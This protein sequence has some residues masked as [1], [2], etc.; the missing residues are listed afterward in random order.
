[1]STLTTQEYLRSQYGDSSNL[2]ARAGL[3]VRFSTEEYPWFHRVFDHF[4]IPDDGRLLDLGC[5]T[6]PLWRDNLE[7]IPRGWSVT[8]SDAS[9]GMVRDRER[10][11]KSV[12][13]KHP[14]HCQSHE[15]EDR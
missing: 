10:T 12:P 6:G 2:S 11:P 8:L 5:G 1:M 13:E 4:D 15:R 7:R 3:Q 14:C 9:Q